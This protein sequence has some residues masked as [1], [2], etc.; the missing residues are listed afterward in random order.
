VL[1]RRRK[2]KDYSRE[3]IRES[4]GWEKEK[5]GLFKRENKGEC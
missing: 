2:R 4:A 5:K 1:G 3:R